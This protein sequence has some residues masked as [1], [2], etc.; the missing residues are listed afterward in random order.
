MTNE[1]LQRVEII[2]FRNFKEKIRLTKRYERLAKMEI[3]D[4][5][6]IYLEWR[7]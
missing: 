2:N 4:N 6:Y 7:I 3:I 1:N 5:K